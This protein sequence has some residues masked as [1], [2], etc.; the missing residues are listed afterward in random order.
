LPKVTN[1]KEV[2]ST[3]RAEKSLSALTDPQRL[4]QK[5]FSRKYQ[6]HYFR[7]DT[8]ARTKRKPRGDDYDLHFRSGSAS[9][10]LTLTA[11]NLT[12]GLR[13][14]PTLFERK[15]RGWPE[16]DDLICRDEMS[17]GEAEAGVRLYR[18][19]WPSL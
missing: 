18:S 13:Y 15:P 11:K 4:R 17:A 14:L 5:V 1:A 6:I 7:R 12:S 16:C 2:A 19:E 3:A 10:W 9:L 8:M